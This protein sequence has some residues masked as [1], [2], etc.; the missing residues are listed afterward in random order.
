MKRI[1]FLIVAASAFLSYACSQPLQTPT[2][3][4]GFTQPANYEQI[5]Q[6]CE[7]AAL[8][9]D[10]L[11]LDIFGQSAEGRDLLVIKAKNPKV[12]DSE[13]LR[14][15]FFAQQHGNEQ[16]SKEG[17]LLLIRDLAEGKYDHWLQRME[18]WIVPQVN[19]DGG[20]ENRRANSMN[21]D[22][23]RD[24]VVMQ[25][26]ET[27]ALHALFRGFMPHVSI[28]VHEYQPYRQ[29]WSNYGGYKQFDVQVGVTTNINIDQTI[30]QYSLNQVLDHIERHLT[31]RGFS[32]H[33]YLVGPPPSEGITR[34][35]TV[36]INDGRQ[37]FGILQT[38]SFIYEG[39][40]GRDGFAENLAHRSQGQLEAKLALMNYMY[41]NHHEVVSMVNKAREMMISAKMPETVAIRT[42]YFP[43]EEPLELPLKS[44]ATGMDTIVIVD[45]YHPLVKPLLEVRRPMGYVLPAHDKKLIEWLDLHQIQYK[46][47]LPSGVSVYA[48]EAIERSQTPYAVKKVLS[49]NQQDYVYVPVNQLHGNF[50]VLTLE[51]LSELSIARLPLF[52]Y[53]LDEYS[54]YPIHRV[55]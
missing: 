1:L 48:C 21:L 25:A 30:Q 55:D 45:N 38:M 29:A 5:R 50:L 23:N 18:I 15:L 20:E 42:G 8:L 9:H 51:P 27:R 49:I 13:T 28:D 54:M 2:E 36:D 41:E 19:P 26:P 53:L 12:S 32:F 44:S 16:A 34:H 22:L 24:H 10:Q 52:S 40:N 35:S 4:T 31:D 11:E 37:S 17:S 14:V 43:G 6:F 3:K 7:E 39:I 33:N 47:D 46:N